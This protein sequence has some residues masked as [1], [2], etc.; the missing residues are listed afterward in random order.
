MRQGTVEHFAG[1]LVIQERGI[2]GP[3]RG[4]RV[5]GSGAGPLNR[6]F[7]KQSQPDPVFVV[8]ARKGMG[9]QRGRRGGQQCPADPRTS[10][11]ATTAANH[12][13]DGDSRCAAHAIRQGESQVIQNGGIRLPQIAGA[14]GRDTAGGRPPE[15][16]ADQ[17][18]TIDAELPAS[19]QVVGEQNIVIEKENPVTAS[20]VTV[21]E[22]ERQIAH[23]RKIPRPCSERAAGFLQHR[24]R[25]WRNGRVQ[26][27]ALLLPEDGDFKTQGRG[28]ARGVAHPARKVG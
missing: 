17:R 18:D 15:K 20:G 10:A 9:K 26:S 28:A 21:G 24:K 8:A 4:R 22:Q 5:Q 25:A 12:E 6:A 14:G 13:P 27:T 11:D 23:T 1:A 7:A 3:L 16:G 19:I 2:N